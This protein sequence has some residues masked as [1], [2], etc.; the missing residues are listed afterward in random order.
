MTE[1]SVIASGVGFRNLR[2]F[3]LDG[4]GY[5]AAPDENAYEGVLVSGVKNFNVTD[6]E[7]R[8]ITHVGDDAPFA[9]DILPPLEAITGQVSVGKQND[10]LDAVLTGLKSYTVGETKLFSVG[11]D[12]RGFEA[13]VG[14]LAYRQTVDTDP[15]SSEYGA[16][17]W[18][19]KIL[20]KVTFFPLE[21]GYS[22]ATEER[23]YTVRPSFV[24]EH[25]W[26][27]AFS[28][29]TEGCNRAQLVRGISQYKPKIV[30][31]RG[32]ALTTDFLFPTDA[33]AQSADKTSVWRNG[34]IQSAS[35]TWDAASISFLVAPDDG[36]NITVLYETT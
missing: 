24:T 16:R 26:G 7:P 1:P 31:F 18:Q 12:K 32:D 34:V 29:A 2:V 10:T 23:M 19:F 30:A 28:E 22:E 9:L 25:I 4:N 15:T 21:S 33:Q 17:R 3:A 6:P 36:D 20:P 27:T 11:T 14:A 5:I 35:Y 13:V 8:L